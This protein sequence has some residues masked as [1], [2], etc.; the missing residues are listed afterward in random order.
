LE[1]NLDPDRLNH[2]VSL[3]ANVGVLIGIVF[4]AYE[5]H[6]NNDLLES[7]SQYRLFENRRQLAMDLYRDP[8]LAD[9]F[10]KLRS[11]DQLT[12]NEQMR[13]GAFYRS[14]YQNWLWE[15]NEW[16]Q[17]RLEELPL[18]GW[19][20]LAN[21][22]EVGRS[23]LRGQI[24]NRIEYGGLEVEFAEFLEEVLFGE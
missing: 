18:Q 13:A 19:K 20:N 23:V 22:N 6:Q 21:L 10:L 5:L 4:L 24:Q 11:G 17:G 1:W 12:A 7:E 9:L 8:V 16:A 14:A 2:L 3:G 15:Y